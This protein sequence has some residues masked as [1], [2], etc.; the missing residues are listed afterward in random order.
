M[1]DYNFDGGY[2]SDFV[3]Q[4]LRA[5]VLIIVFLSFL[6]SLVAFV[7][8]KGI[9]VPSDYALIII[10]CFNK[11]VVVRNLTIT[12]KTVNTDSD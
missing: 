1:Y 11:K 6:T 2:V 7:M 3:C 10:I 8:N 12:V 5:N 4:T 9:I